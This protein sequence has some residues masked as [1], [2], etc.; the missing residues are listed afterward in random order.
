[1]QSFLSDDPPYIRNE[2]EV[3]MKTRAIFTNQQITSIAVL[4]NSFKLCQHI[5]RNKM[6]DDLVETFIAMLEA[7]NPRFQK[8]KFRAIVEFGPFLFDS[9]KAKATNELAPREN[10][11]LAQRSK[12]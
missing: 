9:A 4:L 8:R 5:K 1:M 12:P 6:F 10:V 11:P 3:K 2:K 7:D